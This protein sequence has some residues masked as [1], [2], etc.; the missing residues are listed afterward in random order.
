VSTFVLGLG[1]LLKMTTIAF[2]NHRVALICAGVLGA[3]GVA[4]GAFGAHALRDTLAARGTRDVWETAVQFQLLHAAVL[5]G[6]AGWLR[7]SSPPP[8]AAAAWA[9]RLWAAGSVL[10]SGSLYGLALG[11]PRLLGPV[12]PLG[13]LALI[14]GW[15]CA[16]CAALAG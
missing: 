2:M 11:G 10:F 4:L 16:A 6:F 5:V 15:V 3:S 12:T 8:G 7:P 14:S 13:G 1:S 9:V